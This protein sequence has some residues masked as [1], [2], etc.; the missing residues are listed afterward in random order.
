MPYTF[1]DKTPGIFSENQLHE[2]NSILSKKTKE[3]EESNNPRLIILETWFIVDWLIR[4]LIISG[5]NGLDLKNDS[6]YPHYQLLPNSFREC[7]GC[8]RDFIN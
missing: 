1:S 4:Q 5:I 6:Y 3:I 2:I 7:A 8:L